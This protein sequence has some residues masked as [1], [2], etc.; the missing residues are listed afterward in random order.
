LVYGPQHS[1]GNG[2]SI[3]RSKCFPPIKLFVPL[4]TFQ[5][6]YLYMQSL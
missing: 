1:K 2:V 6:R 5:A 4:S 3:S